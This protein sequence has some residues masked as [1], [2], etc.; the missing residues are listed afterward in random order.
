TAY[1][2]F[3]WLEFRRVLFRS[4]VEADAPPEGGARDRGAGDR[5]GRP[6]GRGGG[7][8][9]RGRAP[10]VARRARGGPAGPGGRRRAHRAG[11]PGRRGGAGH[12]RA[13]AEGG[14]A[15]LRPGAGGR[16]ALVTAGRVE[17][18]PAP[19]RR[20]AALALLLAAT[21]AAACA[22]LGGSAG[23]VTVAALYIAF[24]A[25]ALLQPLAIVPQ[26]L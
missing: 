16:V 10:P 2:I 25:F 13:P 21:T 18:W 8:G 24:S 14:G 3:T 7:A 19:R 4:P 12:L 11:A 26:V 20:V 5:H 1:E 17:G 23:H 6:A 22:L 9:G 15:D